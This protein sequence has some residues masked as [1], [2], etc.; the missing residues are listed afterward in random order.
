MILLYLSPPGAAAPKKGG[1]ERKITMSKITVPFTYEQRIKQRMQT[2][3]KTRRISYEVA[4]RQLL[5]SKATLS[6]RLNP[7]DNAQLTIQF[8]MDFARAF[9]N[10]HI[11]MLLSNEQND[12]SA[13]AQALDMDRVFYGLPADVM[14]GIYD[15]A[16]SEGDAF[17]ALLKSKES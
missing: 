6:R 12:D 11:S 17:R 9:C 4:A 5:I 7:E 1:A 16:V 14:K 3:I 13:V 10:G 15:R 2:V 8:C